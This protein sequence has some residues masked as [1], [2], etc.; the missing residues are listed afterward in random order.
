[1]EMTQFMDYGGECVGCEWL[2][3]LHAGGKL[4]GTGK[5]K[6]RTIVPN[7]FLGIREMKILNTSFVGSHIFFS[8]L[9][10]TRRRSFRKATIKSQRQFAIGFEMRINHLTP[11]TE[12]R[13]EPPASALDRSSRML[14]LLYRES[15]EVLPE[16]GI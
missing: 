15:C 3:T 1:M 10:A 7:A 4:V 9:F 14:L 8:P 12:C 16:S 5:W 6:T 11:E 2:P 13:K